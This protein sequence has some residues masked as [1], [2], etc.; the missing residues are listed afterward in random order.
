MRSTHKKTAKGEKSNRKTSPE[1]AQSAQTKKRKADVAWDAKVP[2]YQPAETEVL[3][4]GVEDLKVIPPKP[5]TIEQLKRAFLE[6]LETT[7]GNFTRAVAASGLPRRTAYNHLATDRAFADVWH[8][9]VAVGHDRLD[10]KLT[11]EALKEKP[12]PSLLIYAHKNATNQ[13]KWRG[14]LLEAAKCGIESMQQKAV[15]LGIPKEH[16]LKMREAMLEGYEKIPLV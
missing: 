11:A 7:G 9:A 16:I 3:G 8:D 1:M 6:A 12:V 14:R 5:R 15:E 4:A 2:P 13:K 10:E